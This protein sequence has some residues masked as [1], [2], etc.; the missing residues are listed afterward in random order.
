MSTSSTW[1][2]LRNQMYRTKWFASLLPGPCVAAHD[3][4]ATCTMNQVIHL[5]LFLSLM[6]TVASLPFFFFTLP[7]GALAD[8]VDRKRMMFVMT[9]WL[10]VAAG[11]LAICGWF[12]MINPYVLLAAIFLIEVGFAF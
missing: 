8:M 12:K 11:G 3:T 1:P 5:P 6:S 2:A 7:A 10:A 4:A 9:I